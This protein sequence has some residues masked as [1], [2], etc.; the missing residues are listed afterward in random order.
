MGNGR[1]PQGIR[2]AQFGNQWSK[3][4][5][6]S[7]PV[8][9]TEIYLS[10]EVV[11]NKFV[12]DKSQLIWWWHVAHL[13]DRRITYTDKVWRPDGKRPLGRPR[14]RWKDNTKM[15]LQDVGWVGMS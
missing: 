14:R 2:G 10:C 12:Q 15:D 8:G 3:E 11:R 1:G 5:K 13:G 9:K 6:K 4:R 7:A